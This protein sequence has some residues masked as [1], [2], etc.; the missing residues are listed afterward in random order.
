MY[1]AERLRALA[2][3][4]LALLAE[5]GALVAVAVA[6]H[7]LVAELRVFERGWVLAALLTGIVSAGAVRVGWRCGELTA[8]P[9]PRCGRAFFRRASGLPGWLLLRRSCAHCGTRAQLREP[10]EER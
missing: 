5:L 3:R 8:E 9:C 10:A 6:L 7:A 4:R 2:R 1:P